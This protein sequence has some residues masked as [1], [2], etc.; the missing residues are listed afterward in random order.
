M[1]KKKKEDLSGKV[2][3]KRY[4]CDNLQRLKKMYQAGF[5]DSEI[6]HTLR[7]DQSELYDLKLRVP[8]GK[9]MID[10]WKEE[11]VD[12]VINSLY[13]KAMGR[14]V[15]MEMEKPMVTGSN[16]YKTVEVVPYKVQ[17]YEAPD[18]QAIKFFLTNLAPEKFKDSS[19]LVMETV[20]GMTNEDLEARVFAHL[21]KQKQD[22]LESK[23]F[24]GAVDEL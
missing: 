11:R 22:N 9:K 20:Q 19:E 3:T 12:N 17:K 2:S 24:D 4:L 18:F 10:Q 1:A 16:D 5:T 8:G 23:G 21:Q 7:L 6:R 15:E 13:E 14:M